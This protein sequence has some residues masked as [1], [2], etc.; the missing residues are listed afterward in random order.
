MTVELGGN[1]TRVTF[2]GV[3][4]T[5]N[6]DTIYADWSTLDLLA[7]GA[8]ADSYD[9]QLGPGTSREALVA[10]AKAQD[11]GLDAAPPRDGTSSQAVVLVSSAS[12]LT[13]VLAIVAALGVFNTVALNAHE[14]RRDL[15]MLKAIGMTPR[16]VTVM[17]ITSTAALGVAGGLIGLPLGFFVHRLVGPAM[18]R[19]AQSDVFG[20]VIDVYRAPT[21]VL[22]GRAGIAI[23][24]LGA[25]I[26]AGR[27]A[28]LPIASVLH[29][30]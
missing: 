12:I 7:P 16:Q 2:V 14:R 30:E 25:V 27:A 26:P 28:R 10:A 4:L 8:R 15:G 17:M 22:L 23:A 24:V 20:F 29:N 18:L 3:T 6:A 19:A 5:N 9:V 11:P 21:L 1:R 13:L